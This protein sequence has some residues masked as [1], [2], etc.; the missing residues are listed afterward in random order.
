[1]RG[2]LLVLCASVALIG[3][4]Q[5]RGGSGGHGGHSGGLSSGTP[6]YHSVRG[7]TR[8]DGT[9]VA[10]S[11]ATNPN[12]S[13]AD[14]WSTRGNVNPFTGRPGT[15]SPDGPGH[16]GRGYGV[17]GGF[18]G[19]VGL[20]GYH[21]FRDADPVEPPVL[22]TLDFDALRDPVAAVEPDAT[23]VAAAPSCGPETLG[24]VEVSGVGRCPAEP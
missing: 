13:R 10:P 4:A 14:N 21:R 15:R 2:T 18:A 20:W 17:A 9:Y 11:H 5:A 6:G 3:A 23:P 12:G 7:Y 16:A 1:M 22:E 24:Y 19:A 8:R